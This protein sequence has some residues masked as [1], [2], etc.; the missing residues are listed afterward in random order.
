M[1]RVGRDG[2]LPGAERNLITNR[3]NGISRVHLFT[4][5]QPSSPHPIIG[6]ASF[7]NEFMH[8]PFLPQQWLTRCKLFFLFCILARASQLTK[9][10]AEQIPAYK[11]RG[12]EV[13]SLMRKNKSVLT[14]HPFT[15]ATSDRQS[16][17]SSR[18]GVCWSEDTSKIGSP[19]SLS[20]L[21][22]PVTDS[23]AQVRTVS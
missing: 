9:R 23:P 16:R 15:S 6:L 13:D 21:L 10:L 5:S 17:S 1:V 3:V 2:G 22:G 12:R 14:A 20:P 19:A 11:S 18:L 4:R 8:Q 7:I